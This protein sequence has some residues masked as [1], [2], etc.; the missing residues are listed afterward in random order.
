MYID[1]KRPEAITR[2]I[3]VLKKIKGEHILE[4]KDAI[5]S[6]TNNLYV[7]TALCDKGNLSDLTEN[8]KKPL[9]VEDALKI[10]SQ[11]A[12][13]FLEIKDLQIKD[14][15]G[16]VLTVM[17]RD[18][19]PANILMKNGNAVLGDFGFAKFVPDETKG[20]LKDQTKLGTPVYMSPQLLK[21]EKYSYKCD[22]WA[23]GIVTYELI[24]GKRPWS[25]GNKYDISRNIEK[26]PLVFPKPIDERVKKLL[27]DM[28]STEEEDR[29]D[30]SKI[31]DAVTPKKQ[32]KPLVIDEPA[33]N[34]DNKAVIK[35]D[36]P[37]NEP[38]KPIIIESLVVT[39][40]PI[41]QHKGVKIM[42][43]S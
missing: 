6:T 20:E 18:L 24:F 41:F 22:I 10:L 4:L 31:L 21:L 27:S 8:G 2:E 13:A 11:I 38:N 29:P 17:H 39:K 3:E 33:P 42:E 12:K 19:K 43:E 14:E 9:S 15:S 30:W 32:S 37:L 16:K 23:M 25:G 7:V 26:N 40:A 5:L 35:Q 28:L 34:K 1:T 36:S